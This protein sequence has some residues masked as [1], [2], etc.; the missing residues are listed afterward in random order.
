MKKKNKLEHY[1]NNKDF[2]DAMVGYKRQWNEAKETFY[3]KYGAYPK[4]TDEWEGRPTVPRYIGECLLKIA[5]HL[6]YLPKFAN[7]SSREDMIMDA[8]ENSIIYLY[9]FDPDYVNPKTGKKKN[10][11]AYFTQICYFAF[12]RRIGKEK[13]QVEI[14]DKILE[15]TLYDEV[16]YVDSD[17]NS[18]EYNSIKETVYSR[19]S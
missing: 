8:V 16:F 2:Y 17:D 11:F 19:Y 9:N 13:K 10:P 3:Q 4:N 15:K 12:L 1:V 7:Y 5:T 18:S 6:S 14:A